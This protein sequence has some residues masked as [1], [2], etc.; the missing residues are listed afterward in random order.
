MLPLSPQQKK[1]FFLALQ[2]LPQ[3]EI[4]ARMGIDVKTCATHALFVYRKCEVK[5]RI[6]L[7]IAWYEGRINPSLLS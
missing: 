1:L 7:I 6:G 2:D 3:K 4:A 5:S